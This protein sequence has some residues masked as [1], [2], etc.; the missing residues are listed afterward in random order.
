M[1]YPLI[2]LFSFLAN[3]FIGELLTRTRFLAQLNK[4]VRWNVIY[5][6]GNNFVIFNN[7]LSSSRYIQAKINSSS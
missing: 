6:N 5:F 1:G 2:T 7:N 3:Y 4:N